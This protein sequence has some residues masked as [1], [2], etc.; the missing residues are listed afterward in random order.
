MKRILRQT[1]AGLGLFFTLAM[2]VAAQ[3]PAPEPPNPPDNDAGAD[4]GPGGSLGGFT[5]KNDH[6]QVFGSNY[7]A[8]NE[9]VAGDVV[10]VMGS[11][12][13]AGAVSHDAVAVMGGNTVDGSVAHDVVAVMGKAVV[14]GTVGRNV[15]AVGGGVTLGPAA[16]VGGDVIS[17][18][19]TIDR[20]PGAIVGGRIVNQSF[21][22]GP[23]GRFWTPD[24]VWRHDRGRSDW[25]EG[26][27]NY[28]RAW[29]WTFALF[30]LGLY[31]LLAALF[32]G[33][34]R[35]CGDVLAHR[36]ALTVLTAFLG[37]LAVPPVFILLLVSIVGIPL[38]PLLVCALV[39]CAL[40]GKAAIY[41]LL[42]RSLANDR[43]HPAAAVLL[44]G[45]LCTLLYFVPILGIGVSVSLSILGFGC[46]VTSLLVSSRGLQ[47][48]PQTAAVP[49]VPT[50]PPTPPAPIPPAAAPNSSPTAVP[51]DP[52][53]PVASP[54]A[55]TAAP[56]LSSTL[57]RAGF[58][59]RIAA[60]F[61][62]AVIVGVGLHILV[63]PA[64]L[65]FPVFFLF[66]PRLLILAVYGALM[67]KFKGTTI[68]GMVCGLHV[69][70]LDG[71]PIEW[72]T[73]IVRALGCILSAAAF[74]LGFIWIA[75]DDG[76][77][78]WHDKIAGTAV[79]R[80]KGI[81]LV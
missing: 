20:A 64:F 45:A 37:L 63:L 79:V 40:F 57:P 7:I 30:F 44:G 71:R 14:N 16:V 22:I 36:P 15:V 33:G 42:G 55:V 73:A 62:D 32:P 11:N 67:W 17:I 75:V 21:G 28:Y 46:A 35:R 19:G 26:F 4:S 74:C 52:P 80:A 9:R 78:A 81:S 34:V 39:A 48:P 47:H 65:L 24:I 54:A 77:Q 12:S 6:V 58:W 8:A 66:S 13:V 60:L 2:A 5:G 43:L 29:R 3:P 59:I 25:A 68:G 38:S 23:H 70:R 31:A 18:G 61:I 56:S 72:D 27:S 50:P 41:A 69:V 10:A 49:V 1:A 76:K 53:P 51:A